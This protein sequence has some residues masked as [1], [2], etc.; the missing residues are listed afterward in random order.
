QLLAMD[1]DGDGKPDVVWGGGDSSVTD[2]SAA[3]RAA[4]RDSAALFCVRFDGK[5]IAGADTFDF[6]HLDARPRPEVAGT[7]NLVVATTYHSG[8]G[9]TGGGRLWAGGPRGVPLRG[10]PVTLPSP[11]STPPLLVNEGFSGWRVLVGCE[12]GRVREVDA[13]GAVV[14]STGAV[15]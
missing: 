13:A 2:T 6:A 7:P 4:V 10:F 9:D 8:P 12:D 5:G 15:V 1:M 3:V 14:S 11:A